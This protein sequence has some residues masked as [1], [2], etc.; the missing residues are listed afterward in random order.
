MDGQVQEHAANGTEKSPK[1]KK[2][3]K[4]S[5]KK[6]AENLRQPG[7]PGKKLTETFAFKFERA[8]AV[9]MAVFFAALIV[10]LTRSISAGD[11][12]TYRRFNATVA[13]ESATAISYWVDS[14]YKDLRVFT[15]ANVFLTGDIDSVRDY[16]MENTQLVASDFDY[17]GICD[18][19][20]NLYTST[21]ETASVRG[22]PFFSQILTSGADEYISDPTVS[23]V[24]GDTVV[25]VAVS[26]VNANGNVY[27]IF[28]GAIPVSIIEH[29]ITRINI[30]GNGYIFALDGDGTI[31]AHSGNS[32]EVGQNYYEMGDTASGL[33]GFRDIAD[34]MIFGKNGDGIVKDRRAKK[35]NYIF[36]TPVDGTNWSLGISVPESEIRAGARRSSFTIALCAIV[37]GI[38]LLLFT[39]VYLHILLRPLLAL[40]ASIKEIASGDADL[41]KK[42][43]V[44]TKDEIGD[45]VQGFNQFTENLRKII[46]GVKD[47]KEELTD[48]DGNMQHTAL[49]TAGSIN[50][51]LEHIDGVIGKV[52]SQSKSVQQTADVVT[53]IAK[54]IESLN[55]LIEGQT[56]GVGE[57]STAVKEMLSNISTVARNTEQMADSFS[58]LE[59]AAEN[60]VMKQD[61]VN[62][63]IVLIQ[64]QSKMLVAA[65]RAIAKIASQTNLLSMN[66]AIEAAHA[67]EAGAGFGVVA[68]EVR[69]LAETSAAESKSI[70]NELKNISEL[71][72]GMVAASSEAK[73]AFADVKESIQKT[74]ELVRQIRTAMHESEEG[75]KQITD[76]L[77]MM[78]DSTA[79]VRTSSEE[80]SKGNTAILGEVKL[81][82]EATDVIK[83]SVTEMSESARQIKGNGDTLGDISESMGQTIGHIGSQIDL[84]KV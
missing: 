37:I 38:L 77:R 76:A 71:V 24:T 56:S 20:G 80:M 42:I 7:E 67:G 27:G 46:S 4:L 6:L 12:E 29:E 17:V 26:A 58:E 55:K 70:G 18:T 63:Q 53:Q 66:A 33:V 79:E 13:T 3:R 25:Y 65:N 44:H 59:R 23:T 84:F 64:E 75:S 40:K 16:M 81:L 83:V 50:Q 49:E 78:N 1:Q 11:V 30:T 57:A 5:F 61:A 54:N 60:G 39:A 22:E 10:I 41:T 82:Q 52:D 69:K 14:Y 31:I 32:A 21:N 73:R 34:N 62:N 45:V 68:D 9:L 36:Y 74:D 48:I 8:L 28:L 2:G 51:I 19:E 15:K 43:D 47:S 72:T 35:T